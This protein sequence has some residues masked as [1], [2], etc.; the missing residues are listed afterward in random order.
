MKK[1]KMLEPKP[2]PFCGALPRVL[3]TD[4]DLMG[5]AWGSVMCLNPKCLVNP[6]CRDNSAIADDRGSEAYKQLAIRNWNRR[7]K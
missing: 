4:P 3:P 1:E 7:A 6:E 2:C 5:N